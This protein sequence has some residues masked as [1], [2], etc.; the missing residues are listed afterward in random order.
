MDRPGLHNLKNRRKNSKDLLVVVNE[1]PV[2]VKTKNTNT[3][4]YD[5]FAGVLL[6]LKNI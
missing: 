5:Y 6:C 3:F 1:V 2:N 4:K